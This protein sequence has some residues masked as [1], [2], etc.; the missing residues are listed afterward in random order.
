VRRFCRRTGTPGILD[1]FANSR[2][3]PINRRDDIGLEVGWIVIV[4]VQREPGNRPGSILGPARHH[5][6]LA[7]SGWGAD[8]NQFMSDS[9]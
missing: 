5:R 9:F 6:R 4:L 2:T 8:Q 3:D 1:R 7:K